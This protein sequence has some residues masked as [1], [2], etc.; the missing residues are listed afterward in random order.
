MEVKLSK[1]S[2]RGFVEAFLSKINLT[3]GTNLILHS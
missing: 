1:E 2:G 3:Y